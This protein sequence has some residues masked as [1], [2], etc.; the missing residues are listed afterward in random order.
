MG[1]RFGNHHAT[2]RMADENDLTVRAVNCS[3]GGGQVVGQGFGRILN[4]QDIVSLVFQNLVNAR[5]T[6]TVHKAAVNEDDRFAGFGAGSA[7]LILLL[8]R[9]LCVHMCAF[10]LLFCVCIVGACQP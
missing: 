6:R 5:P 9:F 4:H 2:I 1:S 3:F 10:L 8:I 7:S